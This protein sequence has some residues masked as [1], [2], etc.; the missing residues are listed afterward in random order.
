[1]LQSTLGGMYKS[2]S[3]FRKNTVERLSLI[4]D[5]ST[6]LKMVPHNII[7]AGSDKEW[8]TVGM[9]MTGKAKNGMGYDQ[10]YAWCVRWAKNEDRILQVRAYLDTAL[11][12]RLIESNE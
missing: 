11:V 2:L 3:D 4:L 1:M 12:D 7:G 9:K 8:T 6:P 10:T 5:V